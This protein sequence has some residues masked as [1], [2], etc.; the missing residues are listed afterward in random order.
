MVDLKK[1]KGSTTGAIVGVT[2]RPTNQAL[3]V[4][5]VC[6][7]LW[8]KRKRS[9]DGG[10][11]GSSFL[12]PIRKLFPTLQHHPP[13]FLLPL[14]LSFCVS[15]L[16]HLAQSTLTSSPR[17]R[18]LLLRLLLFSVSVCTY[19]HAHSLTHTQRQEGPRIYR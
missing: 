10:T 7:S 2:K 4:V 19:T 9:G 8:G 1:K 3:Q 15:T 12:F 5:V 18:P 13:F 11:C 14:S 6:S 16:F 17:R